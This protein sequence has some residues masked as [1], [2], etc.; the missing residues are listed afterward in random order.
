MAASGLQEFPGVNVFSSSGF[1]DQT[2][3]LSFRVKGLDCEEIASALGDYGFAVRAGLHCAPLAHFS[4]G[5][6]DTGT[7]RL[8]FSDFNTVEEVN[9]FLDTM[10]M[11]LMG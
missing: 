9:K 5:T 1:Q 11:V 8:S 7:V 10:C 4:G 2:G 6:L 3:V